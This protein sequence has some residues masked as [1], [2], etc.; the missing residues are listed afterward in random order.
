MMIRYLVSIPINIHWSTY[1]LLLIC[2][3][4]FF[5]NSVEATLF[6]TQIVFAYFFVLLHEFAHV[7][8]A[9]LFGIKTSH[10]TIYWFGG[11]AYI[12]QTFSEPI[13]DFVIAIAGPL[14]NI[15]FAVL[16]L[17]INLPF[18]SAFLN[19][20]LRIN[21]VLAIFNLLPIFPMDGGRV[22]KAIIW[23]IQKD[24]YKADL[25]IR[26]ITYGSII[27]LAFL[28]IMFNIVT[29]IP[30]ICLLLPQIRNAFKIDMLIYK[31]NKLNVPY[32]YQKYFN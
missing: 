6:I 9:Y 14:L 20:L 4:L 5:I 23:Y 15:F 3:P 12:Q 1:I 32:E 31:E 21:L 24:F 29:I 16:F 2:L 8:A 25:N 26:I 11:A 18:D 22:F 10:I 28:S 13:R 17:V 30:I 19:I 7:A 27:M